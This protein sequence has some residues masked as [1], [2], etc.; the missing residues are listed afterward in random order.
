MA[1]LDLCRV[2]LIFVSSMQSSPLLGCTMPPDGAQGTLAFVTNRDGG[3][4]IYSMNVPLQGTAGEADEV[5]LTHNPGYD[6]SPTWSPDGTQI[7]YESDRDGNFEVYVMNADGSKVRRLT[8]S[9]GWDGEPQWSYDG[10]SIVFRSERD[11]NP[12]I[13]V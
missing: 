3:Y 9:S 2:V 6:W 12:K 7:A 5:N 4:E 11:G 8:H 10:R 13:F 1:A